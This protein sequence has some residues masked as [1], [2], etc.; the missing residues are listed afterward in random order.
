MYECGQGQ[1]K[2]DLIGLE[3]EPPVGELTKLKGEE[4]LQQTFGIE[5]DNSKWWDL[6]ALM[7]LFVS[8]KMIYFAI[9]K[10]KDRSLLFLHKLSARFTNPGTTK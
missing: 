7:L 9:L 5:A 8:Y 4:I 2:N 3:F 1:Y 10:Y 6:F